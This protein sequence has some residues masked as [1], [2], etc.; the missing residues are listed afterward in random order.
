MSKRDFDAY[1]ATDR[2]PLCHRR[3]RLRVCVFPP[4]SYG[5]AAVLE[6]L[7]LMDRLRP[8][9]SDFLDD[10]FVHAFVE[11]GRVAEVDRMGIAADTPGDKLNLT[12]LNATYLDRRAN[13]IKRSRRLKDPISPGYRKEPWRSGCQNNRHAPA[14]S[15]SHISITDANDAALAMTTTINT[16][17]GSWID[18]GGFFLNNALT[19][20][21]HS[22][23]PICALAESSTPETAMALFVVTEMSGRPKII[24]GAA[25]GG[26]IVDYVA[27]VLIELLHG[28]SP[29]A[30]V[31]EGHVS[32]AR[33]PYPSSAGEVELE[34]GRGISELE[35]ALSQRGHRVRIAPLPSGIS[36]LFRNGNR[37]A[38]A[39]D[40]R[41]DGSVSL[42]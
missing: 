5:G 19:N 37:W 27:Q 1:A 11:A 42:E 39:A 10:D 35:A 24:G 17:F 6:I 8:T 12:L 4:P 41:R 30:V 33:S 20:F 38:G 40:P 34:A 13:E 7:G 25:G 31:D 14:P 28:K 26:E 32:T 23:D 3:F 29:L 16:N 22:G 15:T 2:A 9:R 21:S 36:V 18:V